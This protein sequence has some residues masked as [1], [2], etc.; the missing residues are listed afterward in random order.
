MTRTNLRI[1]GSTSI[2]ILWI[3]V[4]L[5]VLSQA[6]MSTANTELATSVTASAG[7]EASSGNVVMTSTL[8]QPTPIGPS[9][10]TNFQ[11]E[12][13]FWYQDPIPPSAIGDLAINLSKNDIVLGWSHSADN[14]A[15]DYYIVYRATQPYFEPTAGDSIA[16]SK[17]NWYTDPGAAGTVGTNYFYVVTA[18]DPRGNLAE[19]SNQVGEFDTGL[20]ATK[21]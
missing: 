19:D 11:A 7:G 2:L 20:A 15:I 3:A 1:G 17:G 21:P 14:I 4:S 10:S 9:G 18:I 13:G 6:E 12:A 16:G 5:L 8:G